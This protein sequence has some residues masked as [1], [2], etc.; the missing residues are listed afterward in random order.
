LRLFTFLQLGAW[1]V[2]IP[3]FIRENGEAL[4][5]TETVDLFAQAVAKGGRSV[6]TV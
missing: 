1:G 3:A 6:A 2:P 5:S 4:L